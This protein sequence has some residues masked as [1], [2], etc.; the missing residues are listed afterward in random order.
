M[1]SVL[2]FF[3]F[4]I[5]VGCYRNAFSLLAFSGPFLVRGLTAVAVRTGEK[6]VTKV[7]HQGALQS[8]LSIKGGKYFNMALYLPR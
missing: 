2:Y 7:G 1:F 3:I 5:I 4:I 6:V 8:K